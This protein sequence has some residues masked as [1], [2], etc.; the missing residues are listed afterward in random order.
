MYIVSCHFNQ[1][2]V[3][4]DTKLKIYVFWGGGGHNATSRKVTGS[5][6]DEVT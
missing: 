4:E 3:V 6:S 1:Q 2:V 5:R